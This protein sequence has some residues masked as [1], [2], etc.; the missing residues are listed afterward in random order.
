MLDLELDTSTP[1]GEAMANMAMTFAQFE[2]RMIGLRTKEALP[3]KRTLGVRLGR[4]RMI[5]P[6]V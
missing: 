4:Q 1:M 2:R 3:V 6:A 5:S